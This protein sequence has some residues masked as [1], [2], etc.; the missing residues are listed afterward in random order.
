MIFSS[1][2]EYLNGA[3]KGRAYFHRVQIVL[4]ATWDSRACGKMLPASYTSTSSVGEAH[5]QIDG[6][7]P[8][9]GQ[10]P[11]TQQ[12]RGCGQ[13]GEKIHVGYQYVMGYNDTDMAHAFPGTFFLFLIIN[14]TQS[15]C[16]WFII[17]TLRYHN[18]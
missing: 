5:F 6:E 9:F 7:H 18:D 1:S 16:L 3:T 15:A 4:P 12:S 10:R 8:V 11:W 13:Q 17:T 14:K 2:S